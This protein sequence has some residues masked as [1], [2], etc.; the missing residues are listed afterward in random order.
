MLLDIKEFCTS[1]RQTSTEEIKDWL[2]QLIRSLT[3]PEVVDVIKE[4][5]VKFETETINKINDA[6]GEKCSEEL[7]TKYFVPNV[8]KE[9][10]FDVFLQKL[11]VILKGLSNDKVKVFIRQ[12]VKTFDE[13]RINGI[14]K[15]QLLEEEAEEC[16][17]KKFDCDKMKRLI[18]KYVLNV[19]GEKRNEFLVDLIRMA[20][21]E[22]PVE[23]KFITSHIGILQQYVE[24]LND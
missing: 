14:V 19:E 18:G 6:L 7:V 8:E 16:V 1:K 2:E 3:I 13:E 12:I 15:E 21:D 4:Y 10:I 23:K 22:L 5:M 17:I 9:Q 11:F 24:R 20:S